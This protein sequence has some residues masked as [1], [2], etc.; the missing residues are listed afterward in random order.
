MIFSVEKKW[1]DM[2][3]PLWQLKQ[4]S[5]Q[6]SNAALDEMSNLGEDEIL[7]E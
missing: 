5:L 1:D 7:A 6:I 2:S 3:R 4:V